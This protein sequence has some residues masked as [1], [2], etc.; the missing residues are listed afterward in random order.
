MY[1]YVTG[2]VDRVS[3]VPSHLVYDPGTALLYIADTG[4]SRIAALDTTSGEVG[5]ALQPMEPMNTYNVIDDAVITDVVSAGGDL[6]QP[7]GLEFHDGLLYVTDHATGFI[8]AYDL[9]GQRVN[10]LDT[11]FGEDALAGIAFGPEDGRLYLVN[12]KTDE[13]LRIEPL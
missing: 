9:D 7:S 8:H 4:N 5:A 13:V 2:E 3:R 10:W 12:M 1:Q 11:G 6:D